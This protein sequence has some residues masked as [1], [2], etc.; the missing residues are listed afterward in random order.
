VPKKTSLRRPRLVELVGPP[1]AGKS[2]IFDALLARGEE[3]ERSPRLRE[4]DSLRAR[5]VAAVVATLLRHRALGPRVTVEQIR[6]MVYLRALP[7]ILQDG[8]SR[9]PRVIVFDQGPVFSLTRPS[10]R[11]ERLAQWSARTFAA[12]GAL[13][14]VVVWLDAPDAVMIERINARDKWHRLKGARGDTAA[15]DLLTSRAVY[16][17]ALAKLAPPPRGPTIVRFDTSRCS[18]DD[19]VDEVLAAVRGRATPTA[20]PA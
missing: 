10:L 5:D 4:T 15:E 16:E 12:W 8:G 7:R 9:G 14:D 1:A 11:D 2:T 20:Q 3:V 6:M 19:V 17:D 18:V 13:L